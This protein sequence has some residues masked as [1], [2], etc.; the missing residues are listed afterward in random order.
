[1]CLKDPKVR[2]S[3]ATVLVAVGLLAFGLNVKLLGILAL[4]AWWAMAIV[5]YIKS[6]PARE[7]PVLETVPAKAPA[8]KRGRKAKQGRKKA[9]KKAVSKAAGKPKK[10]PGR[11]A[12]KRK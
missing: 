10:K 1:M 7:V 8:K 4:A 12:K 5:I 2:F 3:V 6:P 9:A 11:K